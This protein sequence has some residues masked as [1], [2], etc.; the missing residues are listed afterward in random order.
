VLPL[1]PFAWWQA[2]VVDHF[3]RKVLALAVFRSE[4]SAVEVCALLDEARRQARAFPKYIVT[5]HGAQFRQE[6]RAWCQSH[7][8]KPRYG[9]I[10]R[11]GSIAIVERFWRSFK[12]EAF[13]FGLRLPP[14]GAA[15][16]HAACH[17]YVGWFNEAR[18]H[19]GIGA[20]TP[21]E[22]YFCRRP[23][24]RRPRLEPRARY[25]AN[26]PCARPRVSV[27]GSCG[28]KVKLIVSHP[29]GASHLPVVRLQRAA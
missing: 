2:V 28:A 25:P 12:Q 16:M 4:P 14:L 20:R 5:D 17:S 27:R 11:Y 23:A 15:A 21:N 24:H 10:G 29:D 1:W 9:A 3:S 19:Q 8:V 7:G 13:G 26:A 6:Y 18:P 22:V